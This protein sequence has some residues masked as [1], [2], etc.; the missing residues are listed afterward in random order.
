[1][2]A[3]L[4][5]L[6][7]QLLN[8]VRQLEDD[9][10]PPQVESWA[11]VD[12]GFWFVL[13]EDITSTTDAEVLVWRA[14]LDSGVVPVIDDSYSDPVVLINVGYCL[15]PAGKLARAGYYGRMAPEGSKWV[16]TST[17]ECLT[18]CTPSGAASITQPT[19][20]DAT[21]GASYSFSITASGVTGLSATNL[22]D[23]LTFS[24]G[25]ISGTPTTAGHKWIT[26][27]GT[28][29]DCTITKLA[30]LTVLEG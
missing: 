7:Q 10:S 4:E 2:S 14:K 21:V 6:V 19:F 12:E 18:S 28:S 29:G 3:Q 27:T 23:G 11:E 13:G 8:R 9:R 20:P 15:S 1:M 17:Y 25:S 30:K 26:I 22:P 5:R 16:P 24:G